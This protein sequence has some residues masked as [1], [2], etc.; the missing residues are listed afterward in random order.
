M[1]VPGYWAD[2]GHG[3]VNGV[4]W[5]RKKVRVPVSVAGQPAKLNLGRIVDADSVFVNG[6][7]VGTTGYQYPPRWYT[8]PA[9]MLKAGQPLQQKRPASLTVQDR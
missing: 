6:Q 1:Q 3:A 2:A 7:F 8:I 9:G 4:F 5:F